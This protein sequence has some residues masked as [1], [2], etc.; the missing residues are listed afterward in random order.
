MDKRGRGVA[1]QWNDVIP[2]K[3]KLHFHARPLCQPGD[4]PTQPSFQRHH[5]YR[6]RTTHLGRQKVPG[7]PLLA[8]SRPLWAWKVIHPHSK[9]QLTQQVACLPS[10]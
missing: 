10:Y 6:Q 5:H 2:Y 1:W 8:Q 3:E 7:Q 4:G 9:T